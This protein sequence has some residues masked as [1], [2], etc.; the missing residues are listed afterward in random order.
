MVT[1]KQDMWVAKLTCFAPTSDVKC[2]LAGT[3]F[4]WG[5]I[6]VYNPVIGAKICLG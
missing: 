2:T 1:N 6:G 5:G 3:I 4:V